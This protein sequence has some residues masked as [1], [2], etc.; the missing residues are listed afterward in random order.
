MPTPTSIK[1]NVRD[2][3]ASALSGVAASVYSSVPEAVIPPACI[4]IPGTTYLESTLING[5]VTK[6]KINFTVTAAVAYNSNAGALDNLEQL[7]ISIL[8]A[9]PSGYVVG[10]VDRPAITSVGASNLLVADLD[11]STYYTQ[12]T[13]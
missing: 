5:S 2:V 6:V 9:M 3:L 7:I 8:G 1:V 4:I 10:N 13:I 11:V 12:Q